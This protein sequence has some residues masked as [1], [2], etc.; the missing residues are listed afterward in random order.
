ML[1]LMFAEMSV[2]RENDCNKCNR[3]S[4]FAINAAVQ[5]RAAQFRVA[6]FS[7]YN[8]YAESRVDKWPVR[9]GV[10]SSFVIL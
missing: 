10:P 4:F 3:S 6:L 9:G 5:L 2:H 7:L 1:M 8:V